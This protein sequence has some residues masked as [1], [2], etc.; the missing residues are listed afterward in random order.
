MLNR[1]SPISF[2][3]ICVIE[4]TILRS[5]VK[6]RSKNIEPF[7]YYRIFTNG[8]RKSQFTPEPFGRAYI[9]RT[10]EVNDLKFF[11]YSPTTEFY[12]KKHVSAQT[13][14]F[15]VVSGGDQRGENEP[16]W[17]IWRSHI[18]G[19][20]YDGDLKF[21]LQ[22]HLHEIFCSK[23]FSLFEHSVRPRHCQQNRLLP[24]KCHFR[25]RLPK[26]IPPEFR[27]G[28]SRLKDSSGVYNVR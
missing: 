25:T 14:H 5:L 26:L 10:S 28:L 2:I 22:A 8:T 27:P 21:V 3:L 23:P 12:W 13:S 17:P 16:F 20:E 6:T 19:L 24:K 18:S 4:A 9:S 1:W 15:L 7:N 11:V